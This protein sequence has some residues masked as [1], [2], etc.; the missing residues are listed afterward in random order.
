[1]AHATNTTAGRTCHPSIVS[2]RGEV[3]MWSP[4][5]WWESILSV[6]YSKS[7]RL[8]GGS[9]F[10]A[11]SWGH[12][13]LLSIGCWCFKRNGV[14]MLFCKSTT[15]TAAATIHSKQVLVAFDGFILANNDDDTMMLCQEK[16][17]QVSALSV[18][19]QRPFGSLGPEPC[20]K[21]SLS[22]TKYRYFTQSPKS[23]L[24]PVCV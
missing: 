19:Q 1:M 6:S 18:K 11:G 16:D 9:V 13:R 10:H 17:P 21:L 7:F 2:R 4:C 20:V 12:N 5:F 15:T 22:N 3:G 14:R 8:V 24:R 23:L